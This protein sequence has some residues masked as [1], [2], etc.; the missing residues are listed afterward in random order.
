MVDV[1][2]LLLTWIGTKDFEGASHGAKAS[3]PVAEAVAAYKFDEIHIL[4][5]HAGDKTAAYVDW[6]KT[7]TKAPITV[8]S[9][10]L[11][12][13][14]H[15]REIYEHVMAT[16]A[17]V[18][19]GRLDRCDLTFHL[20][21]GT[22]AMHAVW[23]LVSSTRFPAK[24]IESSREVGVQPVVSPFEI[25]AELTD[26]RWTDIAA[27]TPPDLAKFADIVHCSRE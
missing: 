23:L 5:D 10:K 16:C 7:Q 24:L 19:A 20:S 17:K 6:L 4:S 21:P 27:G 8:H 11:T 12:K 2:R 9:V 22:N 25:S 14:T 15:H 13:P 1:A 3:G 18:T 26:A